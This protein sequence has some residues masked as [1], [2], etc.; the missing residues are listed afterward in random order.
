MCKG[1]KWLIFSFDY[2]W[3]AVLPEFQ[4]KGIGK[5]LVQRCRNACESSEWLVQTDIAKGFYGKSVLKKIMILFL[6]FLVNC[7]KQWRSKNNCLIAVIFWCNQDNNF[8]LVSLVRIIE[9]SYNM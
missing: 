8:L 3:L 9:S 7:F 4:N 5:G 1:F 6:Q 2:L